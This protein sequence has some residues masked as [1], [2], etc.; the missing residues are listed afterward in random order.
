MYRNTTVYGGHG[1]GFLPEIVPE[2]PHQPRAVPR[3]S[4]CPLQVTVEDLADLSIRL[5]YKNGYVAFG[6]YPGR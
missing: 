4:V 3:I 6:S 5:S 1:Q 2:L